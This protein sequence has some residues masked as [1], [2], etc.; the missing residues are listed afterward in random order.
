MNYKTINLGF[1]TADAEGIQLNFDG[2][3]LH[4]KCTDWQEKPVSYTFE[5]VLAYKWGQGVEPDIPRYDECYEVESSDWL[6]RETE[7]ASVHREDYMHYKLCFNACGI[8]DVL[9]CRKHA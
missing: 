1:S 9:A 6:L 7:L 2:S 5:N 3:N 4:L 8:L